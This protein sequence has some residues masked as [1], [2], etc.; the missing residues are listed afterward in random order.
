M[1]PTA[2]LNQ[3]FSTFPAILKLSGDSTAQLT[4]NKADESRDHQL[5]PTRRLALGLGTIGLFANSNVAFSLAQDNGY[6]LTGPI[7]IPRAVNSNFLLEDAVK[8][9]D[10]PQTE[11]L[12]NDTTVILQEVMTR[13]A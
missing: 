2:N 8:Q 9:Q 5:K 12:Y 10:L 3:I 11:S 6:W 13:M 4:G 7:P 1:A